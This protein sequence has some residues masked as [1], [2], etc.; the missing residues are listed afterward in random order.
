MI[1]Y[2]ERCIFFTGDIENVTQGDL[3]NEPPVFPLKADILKHPHHAYAKINAD[4]LKAVDPE[5]VVVT[6]MKGQIEDALRR[7][8]YYKIP[9]IRPWPK[10]LQLQTDGKTWVL[11]YPEWAVPMGN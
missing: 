4:L 2:G 5:L 1:T 9:W 10:A 3:V 8:D 7:L 11:D 6:G